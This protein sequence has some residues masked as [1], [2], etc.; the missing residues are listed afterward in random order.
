MRG[1]KITISVES[2]KKKQIFCDTIAVPLYIASMR[3]SH[4]FSLIYL[5]VLLLSGCKASRPAS[6]F[7]QLAVEE[8]VDAKVQEFTSRK[9][10]P[11]AQ[12]N[13]HYTENFTVVLKATFQEPVEILAILSDSTRMPIS[14]L[15]VNNE[16]QR[17]PFRALVGSVDR[18]ECYASRNIYHEPGV[19][20]AE[21]NLGMPLSPALAVNEH[22][23]ECRSES[24]IYWVPLPALVR[25]ESIYAP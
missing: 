5:I 4:F 21:S 16:K 12:S 20:G 7:E 9:A 11:G 19:E 24:G 14:Y 8:I 17:S 25:M 2:T 22:Y 6:M 13:L 1:G 23:L 3:T 18:I 10:Y 15:S